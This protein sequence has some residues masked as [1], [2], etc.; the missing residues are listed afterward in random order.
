METIDINGDNVLKII[1][2][3][4]CNKA[5]GWDDLSVSMLKICDYSI[6]R[7][8]CLIYKE[9]LGTGNFPMSWK[10]A[11]VLPIHKKESRQLKKN[12]RPISLLPIC[13]K[14]FEKLI[15]D[16][17]YKHI[18][19]NKLLT[20]NQS[21]FRHGDSTVN[22]LLYITHLIYTAFEEYPTRE[23]RAVFLDISK[24]FD[25]VWHDG[26]VFKLK[27]FGIT[28]PLLL[29]IESY[30]SSR[31]QR[32]ILNGKYSDWSFITAGVPQG[33]VLGPLFF[34]IYINDL[35][36][37]VSSD[38]KLFADDTSLFTVVCDETVAADQL[39][40]DLK[41][42]TDW[43]YQWK[44][45]FNPDINKQA[46]QVIFSQKRTK[47]IHPPLFFN[48][49]PVVIKDEQKHLGMVLDSALNFRS[50]VR[51]KIISARKGIGVI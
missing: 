40:R 19:D 30:L 24:A 5:H 18:C 17:M 7:P 10:K 23:T 16:V 36:D 47:L 2:S 42:V 38:A 26:L 12:Y 6:V 50:H 9:C 1:R 13:G 49:A 35:V 44:M 8:L 3:L 20:P 27:T 37:D 31:Q 32:V 51:E 41:V 39:N 4:D 28:G 22:Q 14:I 29:L 15:F 33:S 43:A 11:N 34:L 45:Q 46:V 25:K 21:G 48:Y